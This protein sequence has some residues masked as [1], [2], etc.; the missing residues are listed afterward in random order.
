MRVQLSALTDT[1]PELD[2]SVVFQVDNVVG[3]EPVAGTQE[4]TITIAATAN[5]RFDYLGFKVS[6]VAVFPGGDA[7]VEPISGE[8]GFVE[9]SFGTDFNREVIAADLEFPN[10]ERY[11]ADLSN[12]SGTFSIDVSALFGDERIDVGLAVLQGLFPSGTYILRI[13]YADESTELRTLTDPID[14]QAFPPFPAIVT[15]GHLSENVASSD[16]L[17]A[18]WLGSAESTYNVHLIETNYIGAGEAPIEET[19]SVVGTTYQFETPLR[20]NAMFELE[21]SAIRISINP[22]HYWF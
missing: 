21:V 4:Q 18:S 6:R 1:A 15:P 22:R 12:R 8:Y 17:A 7:V 3:L 9:I 2:E 14:W 5:D 11:P 13:S 16:P 10:G 19:A 20:D